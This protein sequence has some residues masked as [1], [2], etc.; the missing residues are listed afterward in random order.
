M[1]IGIISDTHNN[2]RY[3]YKA[4]EVFRDHKVAVVIHCGDLTDPDHIYYFDEFRL[5]YLYGNM[6]GPFR[7]W[8]QKNVND[9]AE[10]NKTDN[11]VGLTFSGS[12]GGVKISACHS[13]IQGSLESFIAAG[14]NDYIFHGHTHECRDEIIHDTH[15]IN[16][17][18]LGGVSKG[19][20]SVCILDTETNEVKFVEIIV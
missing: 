11:Y 18:A 1:I 16:P 6:D 14:D 15:V 10:K 12:L 7:H 4:I 19:D 9:I 17:G 13:H 3:I 2:H 8:I 20:R 5:I